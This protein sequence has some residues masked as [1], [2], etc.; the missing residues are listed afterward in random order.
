MLSWKIS[1][2]P[3]YHQTTARTLY[4]SRSC[5]ADLLL[6]GCLTNTCVL[7][8]RPLQDSS[9]STWRRTLCPNCWA[10]CWS[11]ACSRRLCCPGRRLSSHLTH[12][13]KHTVL[14]GVVSLSWSLQR[15]SERLFGVFV[16]LNNNLW[17]LNFRIWRDQK[18]WVQFWTEFMNLQQV[19]LFPSG[20]GD[21][22]TISQVCCCRSEE[23]ITKDLTWG[24]RPNR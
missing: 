14:N 8:L 2:S 3:S 16:V 23:S 10:T 20:L 19:E 21:K 9:T 22:T 4:F 11:T 1:G 12:L 5:W 7:W 18:N 15:W 13:H 24:H 6:S 17:Q